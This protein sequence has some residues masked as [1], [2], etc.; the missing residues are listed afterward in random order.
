MESIKRRLMFIFVAW[1]QVKYDRKRK[2][3]KKRE[4]FVLMQKKSEGQ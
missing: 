2:I 4:A 3:N 1:F